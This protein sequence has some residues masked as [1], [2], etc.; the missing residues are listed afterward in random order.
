MKLLPAFCTGFFPRPDLWARSRSLGAAKS[1]TILL[2]ALAVLSAC[3]ADLPSET[4]AGEIAEVAPLDPGAGKVWAILPSSEEGSADGEERAALSSIDDVAHLL[5]SVQEGQTKLDAA[6]ANTLLVWLR[7]LDREA[8]VAGILHFLDSRQDRPTGQAFAL[9]AQGIVHSGLRALLLDELAR[10]DPEA[11]ARVSRKI[12]DRESGVA[13][14]VHAVALRNLAAVADDPLAAHEREY[15]HRAWN[16]VAARPQV[17][18]GSCAASLAALEMAA[19]LQDETTL[20]RLVELQGN[21]T[22][23]A[24]RTAIGRVMEALVLG[25]P[26]ASISRLAD[27]ANKTFEKAPTLRGVYLAHADLN[28]PLE[29][30][31]IASFLANP[32]TRAEERAAFVQIFPNDTETL[33]PGLFD[34]GEYPLLDETAKNYAGALEVVRQ[35]Q[36]DP[37]MAGAEEALSVMEL[38]LEGILEDQVGE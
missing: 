5:A 8:A 24:A 7:G 9:G 6:G 14:D 21:A 37:A 28:H 36:E 38:R 22:S 19:F 2:G 20:D 35:W 30:Q 33:Q 18:D 29:R 23:A 12:L 32:A 26:T 15:F 11:A 10:L 27:P 34:V 25:A 13:A 17:L 16:A 31:A 3:D 1:L 4:E